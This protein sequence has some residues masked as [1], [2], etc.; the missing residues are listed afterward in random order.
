MKHT[1][2]EQI[3]RHG[4]NLLA[5]FPT[6]TEKDPVRLCKRL[7]KIERAANQAATDYCNGKIDGEQWERKADYYIACVR[8]VLGFGAL[9]PLA[10]VVFVNGD[11]RGYALKICDAY[12]RNNSL[13]LFRDMGG[14]GILAP[15]IN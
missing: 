8:A 14:Y 11:C 7:R 13:E 3:T 15:E 6:A 9:E 12:I 1:Q 4:K 10:R 2:L 5:I